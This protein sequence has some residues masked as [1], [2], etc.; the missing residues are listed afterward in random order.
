MLVHF[1]ECSLRFRK[2]I[3]N[4]KKLFHHIIQAIFSTAVF[5]KI[6]NKFRGQI[7]MFFNVV[8]KKQII[9]AQ[10]NFVFSQVGFK[11]VF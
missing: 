1:L 4:F 11:K 5:T 8:N 9:I 7:R 2:F 10:K 6:F 3:S